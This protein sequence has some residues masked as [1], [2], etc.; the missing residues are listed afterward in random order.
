MGWSVGWK[1]A[2][3]VHR[4]TI[5][6]RQSVITG[7]THSPYRG[8]DVGI[9]M[10]VRGVQR[11]RLARWAAC[12]VWGH[13]HEAILLPFISVLY[14]CRGL[15]FLFNFVDS[16]PGIFCLLLF[17]LSSVLSLI[18]SLLSHFVVAYSSLLPSSVIV[19]VFSFFLCA[20]FRWFF[21]LLFLLF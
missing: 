14:L 21:V 7:S 12:S 11:T 10:L 9:V 6:W 16:L 8:T 17:L 18:F 5:T 15:H 3:C 20:L 1:P 13:G 19:I 2:V 4:H